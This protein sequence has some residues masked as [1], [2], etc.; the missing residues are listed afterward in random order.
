MIPTPAWLDQIL[1][2]RRTPLAPA[3]PKLASD[4]E[5]VAQPEP[6]VAEEAAPVRVIPVVTM[7][8]NEPPRLP[9]RTWV[10]ATFTEADEE[11]EAAVL[12]RLAHL[13]DRY[14]P[15]G[16]ALRLFGGHR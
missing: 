7:A 14:G 3:E 9:P 16:A 11:R 1:S 8:S 6:V 15:R 10:N 13:T 12:A 2:R 5:P 4:P